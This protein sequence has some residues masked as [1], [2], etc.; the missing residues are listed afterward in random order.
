M[1]N[2]GR[3]GIYGFGAAGHVAIQV[4]LYWGNVGLCLYRATRAI[5][6]LRLNWVQRGETAI[7][8]RGGWSR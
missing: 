3:L 8:G 6:S 4:A 1:P 2:G 5:K 7:R